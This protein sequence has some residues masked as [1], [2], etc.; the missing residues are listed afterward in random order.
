MTPTWEYRTQ[1]TWTESLGLE[2]TSKLVKFAI[3][4]KDDQRKEQ[5]PDSFECDVKVVKREGEGIAIE[6][7][8][9]IITMERFEITGMKVTQAR[10]SLTIDVVLN[11]PPRSRIRIVNQEWKY[12][13]EA[14][15]RN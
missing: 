5:A 3:N 9:P 13:S 1:D 12:P 4:G 6:I 14:T 15:N 2:R 7:G 10:G 8:D 11:E